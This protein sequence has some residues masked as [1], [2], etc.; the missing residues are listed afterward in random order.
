MLAEPGASDL[1]P[2]HD[3]RGLIQGI[4]D[5]GRGIETP[6]T[7]FAAVDAAINIRSGALLLPDHTASVFAPWVIRNIGPTTEHRLR[8]PFEVFAS[9]DVDSG[10]ADPHILDPYVSLHDRDNLDH[11]VVVPLIYD[12]TIHG[13]LLIIDSPYCEHNR[14]K[15][16]LMLS[17]IADRGAVILL[18]NRGNV[19]AA[20]RQVIP[21]E[22]SGFFEAAGHLAVQ[23]NHTGMQLSCVIL[24]LARGIDIVCAK[25]KDLDRRRVQQDIESV[26]TAMFAGLAVLTRSADGRIAALMLQTRLLDRELF[27]QQLRA[28]L[29]RLLPSLEDEHAFELETLSAGEPT[30]GFLTT[31]TEKLT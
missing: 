20:T 2:H 13:V 17:S 11:A 19:F 5:A 6:A 26:I 27:E 4:Q 31:L 23:A 18:R 25:H 28:Q 3:L 16:E 7:L 14:D 24:D 22:N 30:E 8:P 15:L 21:L 10:V 29:A 1:A 9:Y 12:G